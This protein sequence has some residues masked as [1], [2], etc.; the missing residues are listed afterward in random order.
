ML[1]ATQTTN[2]QGNTKGWSD[3]DLLSVPLPKKIVKRISQ[4]HASSIE[5]DS[6]FG[7]YIYIF[8]YK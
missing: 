8:L 6:N 1:L 4:E 5:L 2:Q 3:D 7:I